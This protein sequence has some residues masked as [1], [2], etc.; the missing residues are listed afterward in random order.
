VRLVVEVVTGSDVELERPVLPE[1][2]NL[3]LVAGPSSSY[4]SIWSNG[5]FSA[6]S[7]LVYTLQPDGPGPAEIPPFEIRVDGTTVHRS[8]PIRFEV[9]RTR[10]G[11]PPA[12]APDAGRGATRA[13]ADVF[14]R[15]EIAPTEAW[16]GQAV[17]HAVSLYTNETPTGYVWS[18]EPKLASFWVEEVE[19]DPSGEAQLGTFEGQRYRVYP[20]RRRVLV[21]QTA[22]TYEMEPYVMQIQTRSR[23]ND[24]FNF[25]SF[26]RVENVVRKTQPLELR[27]RDLPEAG[28]PAGFGGAVGRYT[29]TAA[30]DRSE[31]TVNDAVALTAT[32]EGEGFLGAAP[33]PLLELPADLKRFEPK[34]TASSRNVRGRLESRKSWE[35]ILVPLVAGPIELPEVRFPYFDPVDG[36][37]ESAA[38]SVA[39]LVVRRSTDAEP[40]MLAQGDVLLQRRDLAFVKPLRGS[41]AAGPARAHRRGLFLAL[42]A[43]PLAWVPLVIVLGRRRS[44]LQRH[45]GL[46]RARR[47]RSRALKRLHAA[48]R[49][50]D[51]GAQNGFHDEVGRA[52]VEYVADRFDRSA[53][54][55]TYEMAD[56]LLASRGLE[57]GLRRRYRSCLEACDFARFVPSAGA[58]E[59]RSEVLQDA[60][61]LVDELERAW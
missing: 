42:L 16:V 53:A 6:T 41:L 15:A 10:G 44:R 55:L 60:S 22:G 1:L 32:V 59:R 56:E 27:V 14:I 46:A 26:G 52:L 31:A 9:A 7:T 19:V 51:A 23:A 45:H 20:V 13:E 54:G 38:A 47:A 11:R 4:N 2:R 58:T 21:P 25:F 40:G 48:R 37:Y 34:V 50:V 29:I 49:L 39:P 61:R 5:R 35:W 28:R 36:R 30:L 8:E 17:P 24:P 3:S 33:P 43:A 57:P 12:R 18:R